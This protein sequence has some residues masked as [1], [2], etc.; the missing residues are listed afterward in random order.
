MLNVAVIIVKSF[1]SVAKTYSLKVIRI[2]IKLNLLF[3][4]VVSLYAWV[5]L[6]NITDKHVFYTSNKLN[7]IPI[8]IETCIFFDSLRKPIIS[9]LTFPAYWTSSFFLSKWYDQYICFQG[10]EECGIIAPFLY[11]Y[12]YYH[13]IRGAINTIYIQIIFVYLTS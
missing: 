13:R 8:P 9:F 2:L 7:T 5:L 1:D 6:T 3:F 11:V 12:H 4:C 10:G